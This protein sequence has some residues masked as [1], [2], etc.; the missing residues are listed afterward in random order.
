MLNKKELAN[1]ASNRDKYKTT[2]EAADKL[3]QTLNKDFA[4]AQVFQATDETHR[5]DA[6]EFMLADKTG[7]R[8]MHDME[9]L[10]TPSNLMAFVTVTDEWIDKHPDEAK[11][12]AY[13]K[14]D[15][16]IDPNQ[17]H[18]NDGATQDGKT[19]GFVRYGDYKTPVMALL[20]AGPLDKYKNETIDQQEAAADARENQMRKRDFKIQAIHSAWREAKNGS[21]LDGFLAGWSLVSR[22]HEQKT[23]EQEKPESPI[24]MPHLPQMS[25]PGDEHLPSVVPHENALTSGL[26]ELSAQEMENND[27]MNQ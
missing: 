8:K 27:Q 12:G 15:P 14:M 19:T 25:M 17:L 16:R 4:F 3:N 9:Q 7:N 5:I 11:A 20:P 23:N 6:H 1:F 18:A 21:A 22:L 10:K 13:F 26:N 2:G 24:K